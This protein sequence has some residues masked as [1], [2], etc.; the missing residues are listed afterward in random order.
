MWEKFVCSP[1][2]PNLWYFFLCHKQLGEMSH[3]L[4]H[5][6]DSYNLARAF[7]YDIKSFDPAV[8]IIVITVPAWL[9][10]LSTDW[11]LYSAQ[12]CVLTKGPG[13]GRKH[14]VGDRINESHKGARLAHNH[15]PAQP[16]DWGVLVSACERD[17]NRARKILLL[18]K[19]SQ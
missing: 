10:P 9:Q 11:N 1:F 2:K 8:H 13:N 6:I 15:R 7:D 19:L 18:R 17:R 16:P 5:N 4:N 12:R 3:W 14:P